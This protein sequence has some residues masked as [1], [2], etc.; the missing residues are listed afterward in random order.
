MNK[1][2]VTPDAPQLSL[3]IL[4]F[5]SYSVSSKIFVAT[6][7]AGLSRTGMVAFGAGGNGQWDT[8]SGNSAQDGYFEQLFSVLDQVIAEL[9]AAPGEN[10]GTLLD[11]TTVVVL[12][13]MGRTPQRSASG[14]KDHWTW[15]SAML[16]G[17][18]VAGGR[19][20]GNWTEQLTGDAINLSSG[21]VSE[22]GVTMMPGHLGATLLALADIDP[23][24]DVDPAVGEVIE[25]VLA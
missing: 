15:T 19:T 23:G 8:H 12:S 16:I 11:E 1:L 24:D 25:A 20:I 3:T 7:A 14:G 2:A 18:G 4:P 6:C 21:E 5:S 22:S 10:G 17:S 13:E 9:D